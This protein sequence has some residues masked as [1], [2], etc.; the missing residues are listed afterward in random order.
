MMCS[1]F[2]FEVKRRGYKLVYYRSC[3]GYYYLY[4][5][6]DNGYKYHVDRIS[7]AAFDAAHLSHLYD[8]KYITKG[9]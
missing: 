8:I 7:K 4:T 5:Q 2:S 1:K 6:Q 3:G 9:A